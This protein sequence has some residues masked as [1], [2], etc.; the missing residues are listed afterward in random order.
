M[1]QIK[2]AL[3]SGFKHKEEPTLI[4][5]IIKAHLEH[6]AEST[7]KIRINIKKKAKKKQKKKKTREQSI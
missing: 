7:A 3:T 5:N 6:K 4:K 1:Y 2:R